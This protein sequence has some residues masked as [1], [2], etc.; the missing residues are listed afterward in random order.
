[1]ALIRAP[2]YRS[3]D[4]LPTYRKRWFFI[5]C[6]LFFIPAGIVIAATGE[7]YT[8]SKGK[9]MKLSAGN[10]TLIIVGWS[11]ILLMNLVRALAN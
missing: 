1:M 6:I 11:A 10:K 3:Y 5:L 8:L 7:I 9:V 4:Q 2:E